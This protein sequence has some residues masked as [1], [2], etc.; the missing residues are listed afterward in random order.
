MKRSKR[1]G[2]LLGV[3]AAACIATFAAL[4]I[5]EYRE[6][7]QTSEE[8]ILSLSAQDVQRLGWSYDVTSLTFTRGEDD[9]WYWSEDDAF[10]VSEEK[11]NELL[12]LFSS[13]RVSFIIEDVEDYGQYGLD[14]PVCTIQLE[15]AEQ[16]YT[17][18]LGDFSKLDSQRYVSIGDGNAYLVST[19]PM[20]LYEIGIEDM[21]QNDEAL[22]YDQ[23]SAIGI[24]GAADYT[25]HYTEDSTDSYCP[26]DIYFTQRDGEEIPLDTA[27]VDSYLGTVSALSFETYVTYNAT[28]EELKTYGLDDPELTVTIDYTAAGE[29]AEDEAVSGTY[30]L[31]V[32]RSAEE[33]TK[34][35]EEDAV[36]G[37]EESND[38]V[39]A[40]SA[41]ARVG[42]SQIVYEIT[43]S[44][45][46]SLMAASYDDLRHKE[47]FTG[48]F[49]MV[50]AMD[51]E[52]EN[53]SYTLTPAEE[54]SSGE[55]D[56]IPWLY[57]EEEIDIT[58]I[59]SALE[60]L[61]AEEFT[62]ETPTGQQELGL[63]LYL[64]DENFPQVDIV[65][66]R[67]DGTNCLAVVDGKSF[68]LVSRSSVVDLIE[69]VNAIV[70]S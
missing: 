35:A 22:T 62:S 46:E 68:A 16:S 39:A 67:Y 50:S 13:F 63:T 42:D 23:V 55:E 15:T 57:G 12:E 31:S 29:T 53:S 4:R 64:T 25:I 21:I 60:A 9:C 26:E 59:Q 24:S 5:E 37:E 14:T 8:V 40:Y 3:L 36:D 10:P 20:E 45:F 28:E 43:S 41:Y 11:M 69:A 17:V 30:I 38:E 2:I 18:E 7:I 19:D 48:D 44:Y 65:L 51:I 61:T 32:S 58:D 66:Y 49:S 33:R 27:L 54:E 34:A 47:V 56:S 6:Q 52:L 1:I 70:L